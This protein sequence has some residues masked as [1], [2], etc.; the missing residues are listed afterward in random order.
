[1]HRHLDLTVPVTPQISSTWQAVTM[2]LDTSNLSSRVD[3]FV[4]HDAEWLDPEVLRSGWSSG[5]RFLLS[6]ALSLQ[7]S[8]HRVCLRDATGVLDSRNV[9]R[10]AAAL[11][12]A[13]GAYDIRDN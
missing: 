8:D 1:V 12:V 7:S 3:S 6:V 11:A 9:W 10:M 4:D 13:Y 5:E 2:L